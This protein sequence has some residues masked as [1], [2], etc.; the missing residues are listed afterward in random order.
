MF[1]I[2]ERAG[3]K[4]GPGAVKVQVKSSNGLGGLSLRVYGKRQELVFLGKEITEERDYS[5][6]VAEVIDTQVD[7]FIKLAYDRAKEAL[8]ARRD[9]LD[10]LAQ[11]LIEHETV[12]GKELERLLSDAPAPEPEVAAPQPDREETPVPEVKPKRAPPSV[13]PR[14]LR[15]KPAI[16]EG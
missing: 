1:D 16:E 14:P 2:L 6:K 9:K 15:P 8:T 3:V 10:R 12:E 13:P 11:Y 5:D 7:T 4:T